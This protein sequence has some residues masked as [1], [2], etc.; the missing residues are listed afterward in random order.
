[1][2]REAFKRSIK[3]F[4]TSFIPVIGSALFESIFGIS[5]D[6]E[7]LCS[8]N[9]AIVDLEKM[10]TSYPKNADTLRSTLYIMVHDEITKK[11]RTSEAYEEKV[12][13]IK[14]FGSFL[15]YIC[16]DSH[17]VLSVSLAASQK[18][19]EEAII[20]NIFSKSIGEDKYK[21]DD[22]TNT[23]LFNMISLK[24]GLK[25]VSDALVKEQKKVLWSIEEARSILF[26]IFKS[27][28]SDK[29]SFLFLGFNEDD[30][31][32]FDKICEDNYSSISRFCIG[33]KEISSCHQNEFSYSVR[34]V[35][36][37]IDLLNDIYQ[38]YVRP[39]VNKNHDSLIYHSNALE[40]NHICERNHKERDLFDSEY[41]NML[42]VN[43]NDLFCDFLYS[44][45]QRKIAIVSEN[46]CKGKSRFALEMFK[47]CLNSADERFGWLP[48]YYEC[49]SLFVSDGIID[50]LRYSDQSKKIVIFVDNIP[51]DEHGYTECKSQIYLERS[52]A[53]LLV[54]PYNY[55][56]FFNSFFKQTVD[57]KIIIRLVLIFREQV[58]NIEKQIKFA[59]LDNSISLAIERFSFISFEQNFLKD[60]FVQN[61]DKLIEL[62]K[63]NA[64]LA[65]EIMFPS[66][67]K[68][69]AEVVS[70]ICGVIG[71]NDE[72][73]KCINEAKLWRDLHL[74]VLNNPKIL[75]VD[76][77]NRVERMAMNVFETQRNIE[78][79]F[80][81][82]Q[83]RNQE[84]EKSLHRS[85]LQT[86][87]LSIPSEKAMD[88]DDI[89]RPR[90]KGDSDPF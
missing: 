31:N 21:S 89:N 61:T 44:C 51:V 80:K 13:K 15:P 4:D 46:A 33:F 2:E 62:G 10:I 63:I 3:K 23:L 12:G 45:N 87:R 76:E 41:V 73:E 27:L 85:E 9:P 74:E 48:I 56:S 47:N 34:N 52:S 42:G 50:L 22:C 69:P 11:L 53:N 78:Y 30:I 88:F 19:I 66:E 64:L 35:D 77:K 8:L 55:M 26:N 25:E 28:N 20:K 17:L 57:K 16:L 40:C 90:D 39:I 82:L 14:E 49:P 43:D 79:E 29:V 67:A 32:F 83:Y 38:P 36:D 68:T 72:F 54:L 86:N 58:D 5:F 84:L 65:E 81:S 71:N 75:D 6:D 7:T 1:M 60:V 37:F 59:C 18:E 24:S 70:Y